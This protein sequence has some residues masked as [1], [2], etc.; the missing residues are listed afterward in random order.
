M[1]VHTV[2]EGGGK[3]HAKHTLG[4]EHEELLYVLLHIIVTFPRRNSIHQH[5][6][7]G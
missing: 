4:T 7:K 3:T 5:E 6:P 2:P 1:S